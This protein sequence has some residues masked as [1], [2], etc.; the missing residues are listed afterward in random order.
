M[1]I[2]PLPPSR[3]KPAAPM[4]NEVEP[5]GA[6]LHDA[7]SDFAIQALSV[8][9]GDVRVLSNISFSVRKGELFT[10]IGPSGSGK[11]TLLLCVA[12][13]LPARH[14]SIFLRGKDITTLPPNQREIGMVFQ[15]YTLFPHMTVFQNVAYPLLLRKTQ[16]HEV[17]C[18]VTEMLH[19]LHLDNLEHRYPQQL[20]GGQQQRVALARAVGFRPHLL[21]FDEPL[22]AVDRK[23][24][25]EL[26]SEIRRVQQA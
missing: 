2:Y 26:Q 15:S 1:N 4:L 17:Q 16:R 23:L 3:M 9:Y 24:R 6:R 7:T 5:T 21:L 18:R 12:G 25:I 8:S 13:F 20:S 19:L 11:S 22:A 10:L 14:G